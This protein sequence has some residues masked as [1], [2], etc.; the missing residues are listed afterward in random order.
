MHTHTFGWLVVFYVPSTAMLFRDGTPIYCPLRRTIYIY[1]HITVNDLI[2]AP[3]LNIAPS[4]ER[5]Q[6]M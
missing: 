4:H 2:T 6:H 1:S 5:T 3:S